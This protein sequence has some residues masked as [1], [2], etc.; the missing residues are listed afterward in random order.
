MRCCRILPPGIGLR[1]SLVAGGVTVLLV[2]CFLEQRVSSS[3]GGPTGRQSDPAGEVAPGVAEAATPGSSPAPGEVQT[4]TPVPPTPT[5]V[6]PVVT[7][8]FTAIGDV[9]FNRNRLPVRPDGVDVWGEVVPFTTFTVG[10]A[11]W[12]DGDINFANIETVVTA[13]NDFE[14]PDR[15]KAYCFRSHPNGVSRLVEAGFN[16]FGLANNHAYDYGDVGIAETLANMARLAST[17]P[18][19]YA[20]IGEDFAQAATPAV[21]EVQGVRVGMVAIGIGGPTEARAG[22]G[23]PGVA[24]VSRYREA[25]ARLR[26]ADVD[27]RILANH[28]GKE[29]ILYPIDRQILVDRVAIRDYDVDIVFGH[30]PHRV[31]GIERYQDGLIFYSLGNGIMRGAANI[32]NRRIGDLHADFGLLARVDLEFDRRTGQVVFRRVEAIPIYDMHSSPRI[33]EPQEAAA[34]IR[35]LNRISDPAYL[36]QDI[37]DACPRGD[38]RGPLVF[39]ASGSLGFVTFADERMQP[40]G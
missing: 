4:P 25:L 20:G 36:E 22:E 15:G 11:P 26:D 29:G 3:A 8:R 10:L 40:E 32:G 6:P 16:L 21:L 37:S 35:T 7:L 19:G 27:I 18:I 2:G 30:H 24:H 28:D 34:R 39:E 9:N 23:K 5:P 33:L 38:G 14:P 1:L 31:Q 17:A 12:I 13:R